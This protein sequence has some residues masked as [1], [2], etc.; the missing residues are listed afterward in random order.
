MYRCDHDL[1]CHY[2]ALLY[3]PRDSVLHLINYII[4]RPQMESAEVAKLNSENNTKY[5]IVSFFNEQEK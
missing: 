2:K 3:L 5:A 4:Y 1:Q